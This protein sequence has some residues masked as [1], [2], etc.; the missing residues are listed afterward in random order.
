MNK[1]IT[2]IG[3][4]AVGSSIGYLL[5]A[6]SLASEIVFIDV[7]KEKALGEA[8]DIYQATP[9]LS[10][11]IVRAGEYS[12]AENSDIVIITSGIARKPGQTRIDLA[13]T[14]V[15]IIKSIAPEITKHAPNAI[16]IIVAN[17]V[18]VLTYTFHQV[19]NIPSERIIGSGTSL[20]TA[21][22][23]TRLSE[24]YK[25]SPKQVHANVLG[26]HGDTSFVAW[27]MARIAGVPLDEYATVMTD[28]GHGNI[29]FNKDEILEYVKKSGGVI[30]QRKGATFNGVAAAVVYICKAIF[31]GVD[32]ILCVSTL[33][34]GEYG[35]EDVCVSIPVVL[36]REGIVSTLTPTLLPEEVELLQKSARAMKDVINQVNCK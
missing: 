22:L 5:V 19:T 24:L 27:S 18:D 11:A 20:D 31:T 28:K 35:I 14:N 13:Q 21:R 7:N 6:E 29:T 1:K 16:Y 8:M 17:P 12:D 23:R 9:F 15:N 10:P 26:E 3:A 2:I 34:K 32:S 30:I 25:V 36:G 4:G 33:L